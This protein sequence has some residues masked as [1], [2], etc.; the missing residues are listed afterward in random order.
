MDKWNDSYTEPLTSEGL[1]ELLEHIPTRERDMEMKCERNAEAQRVSKVRRLNN[2]EDQHDSDYLHAVA[3]KHE[4]KAMEVDELNPAKDRARRIVDEITQKYFGHDDGASHGPM[5]MFQGYTVFMVYPPTPEQ[6]LAS[7]GLRRVLELN[8]PGGDDKSV[9]MF[10]VFSQAIELWEQIKD[11]DMEKRMNEQTLSTRGWKHAQ[12]DNDEGEDEREHWHYVFESAQRDKDLNALLQTLSNHQL[13]R[14]SLDMTA[15][16]LE[17]HG[18][19][20]VP[21]DECTIEHC[22]RLFRAIPRN[23]TSSKKRKNAAPTKVCILFDDIYMDSFEQWKRATQ[24]ALVLYGHSR[25]ALSRPRPRLVTSE[26][27][28]RSEQ[29]GYVVPEEGHY[30]GDS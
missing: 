4:N 28:T 25:D 16:I 14:S 6:Y 30:P 24:T 12:G 18:A 10:D 8:V 9:S 22:Q 20:V 26:W 5:G 21:E 17:F 19:E 27:V 7:M 13:C 1:L 29:V 11:T 15:T 3:V 2:L 23:D